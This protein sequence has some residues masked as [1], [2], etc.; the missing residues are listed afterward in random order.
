MNYGLYKVRNIDS[1]GIEDYVRDELEVVGPHE[2]LPCG[3]DQL[4]E[5]SAMENA[6]HRDG[7]GF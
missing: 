1:Q 6:K 3:E 2:A 4:V 7:I 5:K